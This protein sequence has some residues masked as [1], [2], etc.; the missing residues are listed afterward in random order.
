M[1]KIP[2]VST[3]LEYKFIQIIAQFKWHKTYLTYQ[4]KT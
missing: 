2:A 1:E 3:A 4:T